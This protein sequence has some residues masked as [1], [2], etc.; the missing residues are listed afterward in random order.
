M[1]RSALANNTAQ[2]VLDWRIVYTPNIPVIEQLV[3]GTS[4]LLKLQ[5]GLGV[6]NSADLVKS[7]VNKRLFVGLEFHN[8]EVQSTIIYL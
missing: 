1:F 3:D 7:L 5:K 8:V 2:P 6:N 4:T